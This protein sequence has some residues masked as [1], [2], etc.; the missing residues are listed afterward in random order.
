MRLAS[1]I[2]PTTVSCGGKLTTTWTMFAPQ[3]NSPSE[4]RFE[5]K[6][7]LD[8]PNGY[9]VEQAGGTSQWLLT[10]SDWILRSTGSTQTYGGTS[11]CVVDYSYEGAGSVMCCVA[12]NMMTAPDYRLYW[13]PW[14]W[15]MDWAIC[16]KHEPWH[17]S[18]G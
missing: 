1:P 2:G 12:V 16:N 8:L 9:T 15:I 10:P 17:T 18:L 13:L 14:P 5:L 4:S 6:E 7:H 3:G 11:S